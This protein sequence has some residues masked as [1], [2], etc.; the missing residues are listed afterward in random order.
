MAKAELDLR[1]AQGF[2]HGPRNRKESETDS[3]EA[4]QMAED[5]RLIAI[6]RIRADERAAEQA[7]RQ[8]AEADR[9]AAL[10]AQQQAAEQAKREQEMRTKAE[11]DRQAAQLAQQQAQQAADQAAKMRADALAQQ[12]AAQAEAERSKAAA[13]Q[14]ERAR[15]QAE[16]EKSELRERLRQQ[17]NTIL[18][19]RQRP[20]LAVAEHHAL[21]G[22]RTAVRRVVPPQAK[23]SAASS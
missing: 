21:E 18:E 4:A 5:A 14:S 22:L 8:K 2:L 9:Q 11:A 23:P 17:L 20:A 10:L 7:A 13:E 16:T 12:Q 3:R 6:R 15:E 1:N 19:T